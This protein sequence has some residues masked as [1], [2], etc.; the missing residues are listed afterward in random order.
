MKEQKKQLCSAA[1]QLASVRSELA[2]RQEENAMLS[3][4][5]KVFFKSLAEEEGCSHVDI[6]LG[7]GV[8]RGKYT[9]HRKLMKMA[10]FTC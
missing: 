10:S 2:A 5:V 1:E 3:R 6:V 9:I 8:V 7:L 4:T